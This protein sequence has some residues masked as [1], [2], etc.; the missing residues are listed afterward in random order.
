[1]NSQT[2]P[3]GRA[4]LCV[5]VLLVGLSVAGCRQAEGPIPTPVDEQPNKIYDIGR[6]LQN[7]ARGEAQASQDLL[8]DLNGLDGTPR[9]APLVRDLSTA[10]ADAVA[11][12]SLADAQAQEIARLLF[13]AL[14]AEELNA[15]QIEQVA[16]DLRAALAGSGADD[17]Q[18]ARVATA[19]TTLQDAITL[20]RKRWYHMF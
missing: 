5:A 16:G 3:M 17:A 4:G 20:N 1:M 19:A 18:A 2:R 10:T 13:I 15:Q 8:D 11:G 14:T 12:A 9:P 6:D 7:I